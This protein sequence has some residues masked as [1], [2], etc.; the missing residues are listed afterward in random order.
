LVFTGRLGS[1]V[2]TRSFIVSSI[3][4]KCSAKPS[5]P[6]YFSSKRSRVRCTS[7]T[8]GSSTMVT[9]LAAVPAACKRR[10]ARNRLRGRPHTQP[11]AKPRSQY[12][13]SSRSRGIRCRVLLPQQCGEHRSP[14]AVPLV[15]VVNPVHLR[16]LEEETDPARLGS[17]SDGDPVAQVSHLLPPGV[18]ARRREWKAI[19][20]RA[21]SGPRHAVRSP[22]SRT[23]PHHYNPIKHPS[24]RAAG[25]G[26]PGG[27]RRDACTTGEPA[28]C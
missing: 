13:Y 12:A 24:T 2:T 10:V 17:H 5:A 11:E 22:Q 16:T 19:T 28:A 6:P 7:S 9:I 27:S 3:S 4:R 23:P 8:I 18:L 1:R 25:R 21:D 15:L 20:Q 26:R 14:L